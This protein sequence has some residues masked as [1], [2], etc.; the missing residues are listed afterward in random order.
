[1]R[2]ILTKVSKLEPM[3]YSDF[4][5]PD[6][7]SPASSNHHS[8]LLIAISSIY[9]GQTVVTVYDVSCEVAFRFESRKYDS[10]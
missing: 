3:L 2:N 8:C 4:A 1:M 10:Y 7:E 5:V 6:S 9:F